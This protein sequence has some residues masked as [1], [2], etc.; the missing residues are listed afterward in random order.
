[1]TAA[2]ALAGLRVLLVEDEMMVSLLIEELLNDEECVIVGPYDQLP[3][4]LEAAKIEALDL[5]LLDVNLHGSK[6][7]PVAEALAERGV[8]FLLLSG[9]G[10]GAVPAD[11]P[12]WRACQKP[13]H[14]EVLIRMLVQCVSPDNVNQ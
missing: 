4:A 9:Y 13:F 2:H 12:N 8:P 1:M 10:D 7:Y 11:R 5:A 6:V 14:S 3:A